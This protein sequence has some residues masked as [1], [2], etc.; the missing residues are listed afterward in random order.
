MKA[1]FGLMLLAGCFSLTVQ[2]QKECA[3]QHYQENSV[4]PQTSRII[5]D[6]IS[7][8]YT[9]SRITAGLIRIPVVVH[10][11][12]HY[13]GEKV[14]DLQ[15]QQQLKILNDCYRRLNA[16]SVNTPE[17]FKPFA[18]DVEIEFV[19]ARS[20]WRMAATTGFNRKYSPVVAWGRD[21]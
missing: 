6:F 8:A 4:S 3:T 16:D 1:A 21:D 7:R 15:V 10:N 13:P 12:Y 11:L 5:E 9:E 17:V 18:A 2:A 19:V 20:D 14:T